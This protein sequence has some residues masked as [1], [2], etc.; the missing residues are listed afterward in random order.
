L[1]SALCCFLFIPTSHTPLDRSAFSLSRCP[2]IRSRRTPK[3]GDTCRCYDA[4]YIP[5][6]APSP[7]LFEKVCIAVLGCC[8]LEFSEWRPIS[9]NS[10]YLHRRFSSQ[11]RGGFREGH[12]LTHNKRGLQRCR[13]ARVAMRQLWP[14]FQQSQSPRSR[15]RSFPFRPTH[16]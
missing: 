13:S 2:K 14:R 11:K 5:L 12:A 4:H 10:R 3:C 9:W 15:Q 7:R 6:H 16:C 1:N 8:G